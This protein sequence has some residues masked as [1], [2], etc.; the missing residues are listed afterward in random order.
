MTNSDRPTSPDEPYRAFIRLFTRHEGAIRRFVRNLLPSWDDVDEVMQEVSLS[1]WNKFA[2]FDLKGDFARWVAAIARYEV[3][4]YRRGK[5]RDRLVFDEDLIG[6]LA[7][8]CEREVHEVERSRRALDKCLAQLASEER[9]LLLR[10]HLA[11]Q[12]IKPIAVEMG[13]TANAL[14]K[15][16]SRLLFLRC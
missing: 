9:N 15:T 16:L 10:V 4:S 6:L 11:E 13:L 7:D 14:Y 3:L 12:Q 5:A 2:S 8:E 1:A